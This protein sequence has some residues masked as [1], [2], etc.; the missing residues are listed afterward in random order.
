MNQAELPL[1]AFYTN[2]FSIVI[3]FFAVAL[4]LWPLQLLGLHMVRAT[5]YPVV[6]IAVLYFCLFYGFFSYCFEAANSILDLFKNC[7]FEKLVNQIKNNIQDV[8]ND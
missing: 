5:S 1:K 7:E 8:Q 2:L 4:I 3:I 6:T